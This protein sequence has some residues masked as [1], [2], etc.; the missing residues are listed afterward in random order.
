[1]N[2]PD[3]VTF[4]TCYV[5]INTNNFPLPSE[6]VAPE[7]ELVGGGYELVAGG[8]AVNFCRMLGSLG[9]QT[10]FIGAVGDDEMGRS[11]EA[12]LAR[13]EIATHLV[14]K[15]DTQ[16]NL[17]FNITSSEGA[18][19]MLVAGTANQALEPS[20]VL[21]QLEKTLGDAHILYLGGVFKLTRFEND[22]EHIAD[23]AERH[24]T[25]I[26]VDHNRIPNTATEDMRK[27]VRSLV[28]RA[29]YYLP[30]H[31]E[32]CEL[33]EAKDIRQGMQ[34]L[35]QSA[36][37]LRII[38]KDG[39]NGAHIWHGG[40]TIV[41]PGE[42][43]DRIMNLTGAGDNFNAGAIAAILQK[44]PLKDAAIEGNMT[45]SRHIRGEM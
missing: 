5:D 42:H 36:P 29:T 11:L 3:V 20:D 28:R 45:A 10:S 13:D 6:G 32:F 8:S 39:P 2:S 44:Q 17:S 27:A 15:P 30:S 25:A 18:H 33:W 26:V 14:R 38:V 12:L 23:L 22:F 43:V 40:E 1:M 4:G 16:T 41:M 19:T 31:E 21:S 24:H 9:V 37:D 7:T 35:N 34:I